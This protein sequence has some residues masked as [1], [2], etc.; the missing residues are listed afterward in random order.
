MGSNANGY[1]DYLL[2]V[3]EKPS[4]KRGVD[5]SSLHGHAWHPPC[6]SL[7]TTCFS[8]STLPIPYFSHHAC[9]FH[10]H[11][12]PI[13]TYFISPVSTTCDIYLIVF[14]FM[15]TFM[16]MHTPTISFSMAPI[17]IYTKL[18]A[19]GHLLVHHIHLLSHALFIHL[20]SLSSLA[21]IPNPLP[22]L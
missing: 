22:S 4:E 11:H 14:V 19:R 10:T 12:A 5:Y 16:L 18:Q 6:P 21:P 8:H 20:H 3:S 1:A 7:Y 13:H 9:P 17:P 15:H 2:G